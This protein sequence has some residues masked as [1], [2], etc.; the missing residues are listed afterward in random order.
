MTVLIAFDG[1]DDSKTAIEY[2][3]RHLKPEPI[4][5]LSVW[6]P[7]LAQLGELEGVHSIDQAVADELE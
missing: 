6:E 2:A 7:L 1:S 3:A 4:V 5:I